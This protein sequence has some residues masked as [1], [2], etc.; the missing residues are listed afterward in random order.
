MQSG[1]EDG[2]NM[3]ATDDIVELLLSADFSVPLGRV[4]QSNVRI[5]LATTRYF[6]TVCLLLR[7]CKGSTVIIK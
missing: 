4:M 7:P 1:G 5:L 3:L 6:C 2:V